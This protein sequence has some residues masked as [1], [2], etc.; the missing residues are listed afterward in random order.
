MED[1]SGRTVLIVEDTE[2]NIDVLVE[3][4]GEQYE[5]AVV[6]SGEA[7]LEAVEE[8]RPDLILLDIM[9]PG[10]D[11]YEVCRR[12]KCSE[13][14]KDIPVIFLTAITELESKT[15]GFRLGAVDYVTKPFEIL[16]V[17]ARV[18]THLELV[19]QREKSE[20]LLAN[21]LPQKVIDELKR[22]GQSKPELF[23][24]VTILFSDIV[25][26]T[27][28]AAALEPE[29][30][31]RE[32]SQIFTAF[33]DIMAR[34]GCERIK[35]IGDAY[36]AVCGMPQPDADHAAKMVRAAG[37]MV[38]FLE[39]RNRSVATGA[40]ANAWLVRVGIHSGEVVG[41]IVGTTKYLYD[42][43]GDA[44]NTASRVEQASEPMRITVSQSTYELSS[45]V[46]NYEERGCVGLKGKGGIPL[47]F[48][49]GMP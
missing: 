44:V 9:M 49:S 18:R 24:N 20:R 22:H 10:M 48:V 42:V 46:V 3:A 41:G 19:V 35:T 7:A 32:L 30:V 43:F 16:E 28:A 25:G 27:Q 17:Q 11:G 26:F 15:K 36:L 33:D 37:E 21:I 1:L 38:A 8:D 31:I 34:H 23:R 4:L 2:A 29:V 5:I 12:L 45:Q 39:Q 6:T 40:A 14:T 47:Y 13:Q